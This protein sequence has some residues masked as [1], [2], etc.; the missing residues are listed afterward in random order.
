MISPLPLGRYLLLERIAVGGMAEL[1]I[2]KVQGEAGF[3]KLCVVKRVLPHLAQDPEFIAM[4]LDEA[5]I[6]ARLNHPGVVQIFDLG[7]VGPH[8]FL[9]MEHLLGEDLASLLKAG[10]A[11]GLLLPA[12]VAAHLIASAAEALHFAH[13]AADEAGRP[14]HI[15]HRDVSPANLFVTYAGTVK[16]LD[17]G[18]A[19]AASRSRHTQDSSVRGKLAYMAPEQ[20]AGKVVDARADVWSLGAVLHELLT[21]RALFEGGSP[22]E[23][24]TRVVSLE[25][26]PP[27]AT[28]PGLSPLLDAIA[29]KALQRPLELRYASAEQMRADLQRYLATV[30]HVS[31]ASVGEAVKKLCGPERLQSKLKQ[32]AE[33]LTIS[34][35]ARP[36]GTEELAADPGE[37]ALAPTVVHPPAPRAPPRRWPP[38]AAAAIVLV[39]VGSGAAALLRPGPPAAAGPEVSQVLAAPAA[40]VPSDVRPP[41]PAP[42]AE[43]AAAPVPAPVK[44]AAATLVVTSNLPAVV[45]LDSERLGSTPLR[46]SAVAGAHQLTVSAP[47]GASYTRTVTLK[48]GAEYKAPVV[49]RKGTLNVNVTPWADVWLDGVAFGQT[50]IAGRS[51]W[52]GVHTLLLVSP[53]GKKTLKVEVKPG[54]AVAVTEHL[55]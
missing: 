38:L 44:A 54:R 26:P 13:Q 1:F 53:Q 8:H 23:T 29:L 34:M 39:A 19:R 3:E 2:A 6:A 46:R 10:T 33:S 18:I 15:V 11:R 51:V 7:K 50:P 20:A 49:F 5:R 48:E 30:E 21:G 4:F 27:S 14:L 43:P 9:A 12:P 37:A 31:T 40:A 52:E 45:T 41:Q 55:P 42:V 17:F 47:G 24:T 32:H 25:V 36:G 16:V 22:I 28:V 35:R